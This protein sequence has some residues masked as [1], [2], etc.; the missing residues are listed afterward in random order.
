MRLRDISDVSERPRD[1]RWLWERKVNRQ[2]WNRKRQRGGVRPSRAGGRALQ[3]L[4]K[5][6][7]ADNVLPRLPRGPRLQWSF[8]IWVSSKLVLQGSAARAVALLASAVSHL[9]GTSC[10]GSATLNAT[11]SKHTAAIL[12][13]SLPAFVVLTA[14]LNGL[15]TPWAILPEFEVTL[16]ISTSNTTESREMQTDHKGQ[17]MTARWYKLT[18]NTWKLSTKTHKAT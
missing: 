15:L 11:V 17:R 8:L 13:R 9:L 2:T 1:G 6:S 3:M 10:G 14:L 4:Q 5:S 18:P 12:A 16:N 7:E